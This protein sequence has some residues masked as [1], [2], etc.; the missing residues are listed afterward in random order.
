MDWSTVIAVA[1]SLFGVLL[2][3]LS[4]FLLETLRAKKQRT[5]L[6]N[7]LI[8][9]VSAILALLDN[10][11]EFVGILESNLERWKK[12]DFVPNPPFPKVLKGDLQADDI[13]ATLM[14]IYRSNISSLGVLS[15]RDISEISKFYMRLMYVIYEWTLFSSRDFW[16]ADHPRESK[17]KIV[18]KNLAAFK[19]TMNIAREIVS[20]NK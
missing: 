17:I 4:Q 20:A 10:D 15:A 13:Y 8:S 2:G 5:E 6:L 16:G 14:P 11:R 9:E 3:I 1:G 12:E 7:S 19:E 18:E